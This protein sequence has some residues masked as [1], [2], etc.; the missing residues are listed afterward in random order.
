MSSKQ[1]M[2]TINITEVHSDG[3]RRLSRSLTE[4]ELL[5]GYIL[6]YYMEDGNN[7]ILLTF[8]E[9]V[10]IQMACGEVLEYLDNKSWGDVDFDFCEGILPIPNGF[11]NWEYYDS[12]V[13][14]ASVIN[15]LLHEA[16]TCC[17]FEFDIK[18]E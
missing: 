4:C 17:D 7:P 9:V 1:P 6:Q 5:M 2:K 10:C 3:T 8:E 12:I 16:S 13:E 15:G 14:L 18:R 11:D